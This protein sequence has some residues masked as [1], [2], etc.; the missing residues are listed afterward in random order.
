VDERGN[1]RTVLRMYKTPMSFDFI[2]I[3]CLKRMIFVWNAEAL[4]VG[5]LV[6]DG[7]SKY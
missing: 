2:R 4:L 6:F 1:V 5:C 7:G 3:L